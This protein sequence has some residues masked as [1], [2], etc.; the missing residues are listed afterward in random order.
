MRAWIAV[1]P[2][3][4][5]WTV[6]KMGWWCLQVLVRG[7]ENLPAQALRLAITAMNPIPNPII[8]YTSCS[9]QWKRSL[10]DELCMIGVVGWLVYFSFKVVALIFW[11]IMLSCCNRIQL[12]YFISQCWLEQVAMQV[13]NC[14]TYWDINNVYIAP[15]GTYIY[16]SVR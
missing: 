4:P 12:L 2:A 8:K 5:A 13:L 1:V 10:S 14:F 3:A 6:A 15:I 16:I 9:V 7:L 11:L